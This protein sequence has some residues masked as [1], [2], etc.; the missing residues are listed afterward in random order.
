M[1]TVAPPLYTQAN[2]CNLLLF[3]PAAN[4]SSPSSSSGSVFLEIR[5]EINIKKQ[6][7]NRSELIAER[8][9]SQPASLIVSKRI[10]NEDV[11]NVAGSS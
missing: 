9:G 8:R 2:A 5:V 10:F 1:G 6:T 4:C 7:K 11:E 3:T